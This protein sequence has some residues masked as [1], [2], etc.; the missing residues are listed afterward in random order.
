MVGSVTDAPQLYYAAA[1]KAAEILNRHGF[2]AYIIGGAVRD[3]L[4]GQLP[5]DF[6]L[7]TNATP[8]QILK[9]GEFERS[10]FQDAAQA[11]GVTRV[12]VSLE[13][14]G[15]PQSSEIEIAT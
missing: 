6:D 15:K 13:F 4:L 9:L 7:V 12:V 2:E 10:R 1:E 5:K 14:N 8:E 3:L 11:F